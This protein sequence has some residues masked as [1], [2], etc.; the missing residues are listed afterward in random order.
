MLQ[1]PGSVGQLAAAGLRSHRHQPHAASAA[2][3][4]DIVPGGGRHVSQRQ[5]AARRPATVLSPSPIRECDLVD[6]RFGRPPPRSSGPPVRP[7]CPGL[8]SAVHGGCGRTDLVARFPA[9]PETRA[10]P[11]PS[12]LTVLTDISFNHSLAAVR[13]PA[14]LRCGRPAFARMAQANGRASHPDG[15]I[16]RPRR[17]R[18]WYS[19][20]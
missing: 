10:Y 19:T 1:S 8:V 18:N 4:R 20:S 9:P 13:V 12:R 11:H 15:M 14:N 16:S 5:P 3:C 17:G 2:G 6:H 7:A